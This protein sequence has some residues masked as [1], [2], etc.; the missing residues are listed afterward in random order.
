MEADWPLPRTTFT[1]YYF[2][3]DGTLS[4]QTPGPNEAPTTYTFDPDHPVPTIGAST[5]ASEPVFAG[6]A[7]DQREKEY[8]GDSG[9]GFFGSRPPYL[10]LKA[11]PEP[12]DTMSSNGQGR[13]PGV[14]CGKR[15]DGAR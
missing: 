4:P 12:A 6:G 10:P 1:N 8:T 14:G 9:K 13:E 2:H 15:C 5:A 7:F 3:G 11:R